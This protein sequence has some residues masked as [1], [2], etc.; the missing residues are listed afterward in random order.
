[1]EGGASLVAQRMLSVCLQCGDRFIL[2]PRKIPEANGNPL[3]TL[4]LET[5]WM[6]KTGK[7]RSIWCPK[8]WK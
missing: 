8:S 4:A 6:E 5:S 7:L 2:G 1:M 3:G